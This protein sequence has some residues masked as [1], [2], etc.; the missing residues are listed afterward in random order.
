[1]RTGGVPTVAEYQQE[2]E[3]AGPKITRSEIITYFNKSDIMQRH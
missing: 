3:H 1:M 2:Q